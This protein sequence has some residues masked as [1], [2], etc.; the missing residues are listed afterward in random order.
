MRGYSSTS[1]TMRSDARVAD[2]ELE[3]R[4]LLELAQQ[5]DRLLEPHRQRRPALREALHRDLRASRRSRRRVL[6]PDQLREVAQRPHLDLDQPLEQLARLPLHVPVRAAS[7]RQLGRLLFVV[8]RADSPI[9]SSSESISRSLASPGRGPARRSA[10]SAPR[11]RAAPAAGSA[12]PARAP[13]CRTVSRSSASA[14]SART[15]SSP[16]SRACAELRPDLAQLALALHHPLGEPGRDLLQLLDPPPPRSQLR[17]PGLE[18]SSRSAIRLSAPASSASAVL[19]RRL[20]MRSP[21][22]PR[23]GGSRAGTS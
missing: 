10:R 9:A 14:A 13:G 8:S 2:P 15:L 19:E 16:R 1:R 18:L 21:H 22:P 12:S 3:R 17:P 23:A 4:P 20:A 6:E 11:P 5:L 7:V